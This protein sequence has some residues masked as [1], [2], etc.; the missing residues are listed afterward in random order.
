MG[1]VV[2]QRRGALRTRRIHAVDIK[3][4]GRVAQ[5]RVVGRT[6]AAHVD[7]HAARVAMLFDDQAGHHGGQR[8]QV[9]DLVVLQRVLVEGGDGQRRLLHEGI[10]ARGRDDDAVHLL[11]RRLRRIG[12]RRGLV[13]ILRQGGAAAQQDELGERRMRQ[14]ECNGVS[15]ERLHCYC[16][17]YHWLNDDH[18][19]LWL[20]LHIFW[21]S[22]SVHGASVRVNGW[23]RRARPCRT[24]RH[25]LLPARSRCCCPAPAHGALR[26]AA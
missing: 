21:V 22:S 4:D 13:G 14:A 7:V 26:H 2:H 15:L 23:P 9:L 19:A 6:D 5:L 18:I 11:G 25:G 10:A 3:G 17:L 16:L 20:L 12:G 8:G 1:Q 24:K